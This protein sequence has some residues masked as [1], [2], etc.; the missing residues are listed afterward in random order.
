MAEPMENPRTR[1]KWYADALAAYSNGET[2]VPHQLY[3][4]VLLPHREMLPKL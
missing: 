3:L 4:P 2:G 1:L